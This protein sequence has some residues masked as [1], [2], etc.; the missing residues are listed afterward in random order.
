MALSNSA[1]K[2][3]AETVATSVGVVPEKG[4][5]LFDLNLNTHVLGNGSEW[6]PVL[7][8]PYADTFWLDML[9]PLLG[10]RLDSAAT[11]Y[12]FNPYN[13]AI[14]Y[15]N[16]SRYPEEVV[17]M[18]VQIQHYYKEGTNAKPHLHW[19][20]QSANIP[21]WLFGWRL[22]KNGESDT[23]D[24]DYSNFTLTKLQSHAFTYTSGVINQISAFPDIDLSTAGIS[25]LLTIVFF[26]D[27]ANTST[28]F[29]GAD[30]SALV[31][32]ANSVDMHIQVD[33]P[34]SRQ[35]YIK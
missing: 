30:P 3:K 18:E 19:K 33:M 13:G 23:V 6:V 17:S 15:D 14:A 16:D 31:E 5:L 26:R 27:T 1:F 11:R 32:Y 9:G 12:S 28:I 8:E 25:D 35:E 7:V 34:G 21:N 4:A 2:V 10:Q 29:T 22:H 20:Q 24:S